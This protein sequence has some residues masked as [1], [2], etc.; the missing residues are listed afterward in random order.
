MTRTQAAKLLERASEFERMARSDDALEVLAGCERWPP[1]YNERGLVLRSTILVIRDPIAALDALPDDVNAF[2]SREAR[3]NYF[4]ISAHANM[5]ARNF[6]AADELLDASARMPDANEHDTYYRAQLRAYL[7]WNRRD[8]DPESP[9]LAIGLRASDPNTRLLAFNLRAWM[10]MGLEDH[11]GHLD[12]LLTCLRIY[13]DH[14]DSCSIRLVAQSLQGVAVDAWEMHDVRA[15]QCAQVVF[16]A[17]PWVPGIAV[18]RLACA[19]A[20][21]WHAFLA[22]DLERASRMFADDLASADA[23]WRVLAK[24]DQAY[25]AHLAGDGERSLHETRRAQALAETVEWEA[26]RDEER[27]ALITMA[28]LLAPADLQS[29][30]RWI[31]VYHRLRAHSL[32]ER[33]EASHEPRRILAYQKYADG[34]IAAA[35]GNTRA[36]VALLADAHDLFARFGSVFRATLAA[37]SLYELTGEAH[38]LRA[39][40]LHA[41]NFPNSP[42]SQRLHADAK[43]QSA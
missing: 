17:I 24:V 19:R 7:Q 20:L 5:K 42:L 22:G 12:D 4:L 29:A 3:S 1:P 35:L 2:T 37:Q 23:A 14:P 36:A 11:R 28:V 16:E 15:A 13:Q 33:V 34:R 8:Y 18:Q 10:R 39:A 9:H 38:W 30:Q 25:A 31:S 6:R 40:L 27:M 32:E 21:A 43:M 26:T 41:S